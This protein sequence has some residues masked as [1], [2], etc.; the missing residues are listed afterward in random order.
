[1]EADT[2]LNEI[3]P[4]IIWSTW[5][6]LWDL[7]GMCV[8]TCEGY[9]D[10]H[11]PSH[12]HFSVTEP[13]QCVAHWGHRKKWYPYPLMWI[14]YFITVAHTSALF[15]FTSDCRTAMLWLW[16]ASYSHSQD[17]ISV[18]FVFAWH[19]SF[20]LVSFKGK[21][22]RELILSVCRKSQRAS[23]NILYCFTFF[24]YWNLFVNTGIFIVLI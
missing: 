23:V 8:H 6:L 21:M 11:W 4:Q 18:C 5:E 1:M 2:W 20:Y 7:G 3:G 22:R 12:G 13:A 24:F 19:C 16:V 15:C 17:G 9:T 10:N 14:R